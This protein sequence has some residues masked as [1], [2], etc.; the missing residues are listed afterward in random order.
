M[1]GSEAKPTFR[2]GPFVLDLNRSS[3]NGAGKEVTLR[4]KPQALLAYLAANQGR[5]ISK[6]ELLDAVW[7]DVFVTE[8]SLTQTIRE[9]RKA[10]GPEHEGIVRTI[11][12][13]GY[14]L[15]AEP[16]SAQSFRPLPIIAVLRFRNATEHD[17]WS[18]SL[19]MLAEGL[20]AG[21]GRFRATAV[22]ARH[23]SFTLTSGE[24]GIL[25]SARERLGADFVVEGTARSYDEEVRLS[26][27]LV[28]T[29]TAT[30]RWGDDFNIPTKAGKLLARDL[31]EKII[32]RLAAR[33]DDA[34]ADQA[35][36]KRPT[37]LLA[38]ELMVQGL[39]FLRRN[40]PSEYAKAGELLQAAVA[41]DPG[42]GLATAHLAFSLVMQRGFGRAAVSDLTPALE[43]AARAV[44]LAPEQ[45]T[46]HRVLS[47][48]QMYRR[49]FSAAE[50]HMRKSLDLNPYDADSLDQMGYLLTLR[51][52]PQEALT[53]IDRAIVLNPIHPNWYEHDRSF[54]LYLLGEY[55]AAADAIEL[56]P[57]PPAW[58]RTWLAA[59]YAQ[60]GDIA[61]AKRHAD[62]ITQTDPHFSAINFARKNGAAFEHASDHRHFA[63]GVMLALGLPPETWSDARPN[64]PTSA[65]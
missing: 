22:L 58:M 26:V 20:I 25:D 47:F 43:L 27:S 63:E 56:S 46:A 53:C 50:Y 62:L 19:D 8:D 2:F 14:L 55:R 6:G 18:G 15:A 1:S 61:A 41:R 16:E 29:R 28:E 48:V 65:G 5:V 45:P 44:T 17:E 52:R 54:A 32:A 35:V 34:R 39:S 7:P 21:L 3:L 36:S 59:C 31:E 9:V 57:L 42:N 11:S 60:M 49:E 30:V 51:G 33:L 24:S 40:N 13:R 12:K 4:P 37:D 10:L 64:A 23:S 38:D